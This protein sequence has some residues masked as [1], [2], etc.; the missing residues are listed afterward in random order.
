MRLEEIARPVACRLPAWPRANSDNS[1]PLRPPPPPFHPQIPGF[2][3]DSFD[4]AAT[5]AKSAKKSGI[6]EDDSF[7]SLL[8]AFGGGPNK[9]KQKEKPVEKVG[10][11][12]ATPGSTCVV[13]V[14][15]GR[16]PRSWAAH[17]DRPYVS[18]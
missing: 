18:G 7:D 3:E 2:G 8:G 9:D 11:N 15:Y 10:K 14:Q 5:T 16:S 6:G 13:F 17:V 1:L 4:F 12:Q